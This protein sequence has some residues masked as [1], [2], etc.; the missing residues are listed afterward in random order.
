MVESVLSSGSNKYFDEPENDK[1]GYKM[2]AS[3]EGKIETIAAQLRERIKRGDFGTNGRLPTV[4]ELAK[5][6]QM[7]RATMYQS[8]NLLRSEGLL[9]VKGTSYYARYP[10]M[11]IPGSPLFDKFLLK[12]GLMPVA[13]N[14]IEPEIVTA[15]ADIAANLGVS[16]GTQVIHRMRRQGTAEV[17]YRLHEQWYPIDL[18]GPFLEAMKQDPN[19]N[20]A[21]K[22]REATGI[23]VTT[24]HDDII[25]RLPTAEEIDLL[26]IVRTTPVLEVQKQFLS[27]EGRIMVFV[28]SV[29][30]GTYFQ[31][32]YDYA[33]VREEN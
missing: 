20:V 11:R 30:V 27:Q 17:S 31:L 25:A 23:A 5:E 15:P 1:K 32:S 8:L 2:S 14:L 3:E 9:I 21:G 24:Y 12:Q 29:L 26:H 28:R 22:I 4:T 13:D 16:E 19:L 33:H 6:Y 7:A 18:A 10:I